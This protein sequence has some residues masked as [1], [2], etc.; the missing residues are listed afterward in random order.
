VTVVL[1]EANPDTGTD[2][3]YAT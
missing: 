2:P 1:E 3:V